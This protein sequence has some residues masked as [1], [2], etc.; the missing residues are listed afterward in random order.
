M[1]IKI[2]V[3]NMLTAVPFSATS[4][5]PQGEWI[6]NYPHIVP[7]SVFIS[8]LQYLRYS[9]HTLNPEPRCSTSIHSFRPPPPPRT[10]S[11][12]P[13]IPYINP[14]LLIECLRTLSLSLSLPLYTYIYIYITPLYRDPVLSQTRSKLCKLI[15]YFKSQAREHKPQPKP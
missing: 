3:T 1:C 7:I 10:T 15:P 14:V 9:I 11:K 12:E 6:G 2:S 4:S 8:L 13:D 5:S